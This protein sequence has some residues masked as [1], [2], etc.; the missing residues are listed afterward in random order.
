[1]KEFKDYLLFEKICKNIA[2]EYIDSSMLID[3]CDE[4]YE[5]ATG[6]WLDGKQRDELIER[7]KFHIS[8]YTKSANT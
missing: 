8:E 1:M 6:E 4:E 2:K 3:F 7:V 5:D